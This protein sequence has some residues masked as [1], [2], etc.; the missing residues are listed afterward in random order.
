MEAEAP[1]PRDAP[2]VEL[3]L[4]SVSIASLGR[5]PVHATACGDVDLSASLFGVLLEHGRNSPKLQKEVEN[6]FSAAALGFEQLSPRVPHSAAIELHGR[7]AWDPDN[8]VEPPG[9]RDLLLILL[10]TLRVS[11]VLRVQFPAAVRGARGVQLP[12][13]LRKLNRFRDHAILDTVSGAHPGGRLSP[14]QSFHEPLLLC[15]DPL[16]LVGVDGG[17]VAEAI[18]VPHDEGRP[19]HVERRRNRWVDVLDRM[20]AEEAAG[21]SR[22]LRDTV[23]R[24]GRP[25]AA[26]L[27]LGRPIGRAS[28]RSRG[29]SFLP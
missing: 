10:R 28:H 26:L 19:D 9:A 23:D 1:R 2:I 16:N 12:I 27:G 18:H 21:R 24:R 20:R 17:P 7:P 25:S 13:A 4:Q 22:R 5:M 15:V 14:S 6:P 8:I 11:R 29:V 3:P